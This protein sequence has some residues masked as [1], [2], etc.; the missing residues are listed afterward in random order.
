MNCLNRIEFD[1]FRDGHPV[2]C[3]H[4]GSI[5]VLYVPEKPAQQATPLLVPPPP[6]A[7][8]PDETSVQTPQTGPRGVLFIVILIAFGALCLVFV[9]LIESQDQMAA[10]TGINCLVILCA[11]IIVAGVA[12]VL[13]HLRP[14]NSYEIGK[15]ANKRRSKRI[16]AYY[17]FRH[18]EVSVNPDFKKAMR[19]EGSFRRLNDPKPLSEFPRFAAALLKYKKHEWMVIGFERDQQI[20]RVWFNKGPD[21]KKVTAGLD[22][23][24][25]IRYAH[26]G[27]YS[28]VIYLH[29]HPNPNPAMYDMLGPSEQDLVSARHTELALLPESLNLLKFVCE[30]GRF[31][32]YHRAI[33]PSFIPVEQLI[34]EASAQNG[35]TRTGNLELHV[36]RIFT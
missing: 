2:P 8:E 33:A 27:Y 36:E 29:N 11:V 16:N 18:M 1:V 3:P 13:L 20:D 28:T 21:N 7:Q 4:C 17:R 10:A 30:R 32:E 24:A 14:L 25:V 6:R 19:A 5:T 31:L 23:S 34:Q 15:L 35:R 22:Y 12:F 9:E 26:A